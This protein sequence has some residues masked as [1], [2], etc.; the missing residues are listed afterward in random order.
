[1][2]STRHTTNDALRDGRKAA[3]DLAAALKEAGFTLPSLRGGFPVN[4]LGY[5][6]LGG[7]GADLTGRLVVWIRARV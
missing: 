1:M 4:N 2:T 5:V 3:D 6:E 7:A